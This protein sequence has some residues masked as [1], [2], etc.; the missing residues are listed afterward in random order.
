MAMSVRKGTWAGNNTSPQSITTPG[1]QPIAIICWTTGPGAAGSFSANFTGSM[2]FGT[3]RG[4]TTQAAGISYWLQDAVAT[5]SVSRVYNNGSI[6]LRVLSAETT[7]DYTVSLSSFDSG[8]FTV[9]YSSAANA[10]GDTF[11][12]LVFGG[13]DLTDAN[14]LLPTM[15]TTGTS[16]AVGGMGFTPDVLFCLYSQSTTANTVASNGMFSIGVATSPS[17]YWAIATTATDGD[18]MAS[19]MNWNRNM[20]TSACLASLTINA[21]TIDGL[22]DL[23]SFDID[24]FTLGIPDNIATASTEAIFLGIEGGV[25]EAG[26]KAKSTSTGDDT[27]TLANSSL[28]PRGVILVT[29]DQAN[30]NM[31]QA[32]T[33]FMLGA[34]TSTDGTQ[35]GCF[36]GAAPEAITTTC[37]RTHSTTRVIAQI[38]GGASPSIDSEADLTQL[39]QGNFVINWATNDGSS[40]LVGYLAFGDSPAAPGGPATGTLALMGVG[41]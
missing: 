8:G 28:T 13:D 9:T 22:W 35:E 33:G 7:T 23:D 15:N 1:F 12:Y 32:N 34:G 37:D 14:V 25:W 36:G 20:W 4:G 30:E 29:N 19:N 11:H 5:T 18:T 41:I 6:M 27:F 10:N 38:T 26:T 40:P 21:N 31:D 17:Q 16:Q 3:R 24:G 39:N 2:G